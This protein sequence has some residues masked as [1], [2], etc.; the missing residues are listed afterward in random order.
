MYISKEVF[1]SEASWRIEPRLGFVNLVNAPMASGKT[2]WARNFN[3]EGITLLL[4]P[5]VAL[6][7]QLE[8]A[9]WKYVKMQ[10]TNI[11][12]KYLSAFCEI[13]RVIEE[14]ILFAV[15]DVLYAR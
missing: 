2:T 14:G 11:F 5:T 15:P 12:T 6:A 13:G 4:V 10:N 3:A 7:K 1:L 8:A 9:G